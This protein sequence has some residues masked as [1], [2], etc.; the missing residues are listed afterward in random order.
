[1]FVMWKVLG[2]L[3][4]ATVVGAYLVSSALGD[5]QS[6]PDPGPPVVLTETPT[7]GSTQTL[8]PKP[9]RKP[10]DDKPGQ[11]GHTQGPSQQDDDDD[12]DLD[13]VYP[14][15]DD[16]DDDGDDDDHGGDD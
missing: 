12:D 1:M 13:D 8:D 10:R 16:L 7:T 2:V 4:A 5:S 6:P 14:D 9:D 3:V 11:P 15:V